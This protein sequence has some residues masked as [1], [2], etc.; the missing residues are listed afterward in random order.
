M[1]QTSPQ[2][3]RRPLLATADTK[4]DYTKL[5]LNDFHALEAMILADELERD[6]T[7]IGYELELNFLD[8][9]CEPAFI[10]GEVCMALNEPRFTTEFSRFN[11]EINS[12]PVRLGGRC[13]AELQ[14]GLE[15]ALAAVRA[16][17]AKRDCSVLMTG[18]IP[19]LNKSHITPEALTPEPRYQALYDIRRALKGEHYEYRIQGI[20]ELLTRDNIALFAG[21]VTSFQVHLQV[22]V[23]DLVDKYNWAQLLAG[24][25]LATAVNSPLF[26]GKQLWQETRIELFEQATDTRVPDN[27]DT[28]NR[29]RVFFGDKWLQQSVLELL[30]EDI[31][32][33][34]PLFGPQEAE[35]ALQALHD[36]KVPR[37][38][39][40]TLF[41]GTIYRWNRLCYGRLHGRPALRIENRMLPSGPTVQ[42]MVANAA[43]WSGAMAGLPQRYRDVQQRLEF[44]HAKE[45]F[46]KAARYGLDVKFHWFDGAVTARELILD[47]LLP[48]AR[49]GLQSAGVDD[50]DS[51]RFLDIIRDRTATGR[52]GAHW[53]ISSFTELRKT[54]KPEQ[55]L[56][57]LTAGMLSRQESGV[58]VHRWQGV[59]PDEA[60]EGAD[61]LSPV[62]RI[63]TTDLYKVKVDDAIDLVAHLMHWKQIGHVP[64]EDAS[65]QLVG[66]ITRKTLIDH[67]LKAPA[68]PGPLRAGELMTDCALRIVPETP[69]QRVVQLLLENGVSCLPVTSNGCIVGLVTGHDVVKVAHALLDGQ[70]QQ[71]VPP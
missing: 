63:M 69:L 22:A 31:L 12:Q 55:A 5:L 51:M 65:G 43:F 50:D 14:G 24:P 25:V 45:N 53:L 68:E 32:G 3:E 48:L 17:A 10:G 13:L 11:L 16:E 18:I 1:L 37:L 23:A 41:N 52:T 57:A 27:D 34:D 29:P 62:Y 6:I 40:W 30:Q 20:D 33:F 21:S 46:F 35:D 66:M 49:A 44:A 28:R 56:H 61:G 67:M 15:R 9:N 54:L 59:E 26:L 4:A 58:P 47:E 36:G 70:Q 64:V 38:D 19:T 39:A 8:R 7:R 71:G 42:D 2:P 60:G